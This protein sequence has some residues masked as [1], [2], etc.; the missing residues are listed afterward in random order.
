[1]CTIDFFYKVSEDNEFNLLYDAKE[2]ADYVW[3]T[4]L[5]PEESFNEVK[6]EKTFD[7]IVEI[8][9]KTPLF[10]R[11]LIFIK[12][13]RAELDPEYENF[14]EVELKCTTEDGII[15]F[16]LIQL[17]SKFEKYFFDKYKLELKK[18]DN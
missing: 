6:L 7:E 4:E 9:K 12:K 13:N 16:I 18:I 10:N 1:M 3:L 8:Y 17:D 2:K 11:Y 5:N 15:Y 14:L